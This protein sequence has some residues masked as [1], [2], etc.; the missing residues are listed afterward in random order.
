M[1]KL[2]YIFA[3]TFLFISCSDESENI[4]DVSESEIAG[5]WD[6]TDF[7]LDVKTTYVFQGQSIVSE[8][9][10]YGKDYD[11]SFTFNQN[12]NEIFNEGTFTI[13]TTTTT[14]AG[15]TQTIESPA[16][17]IDGFNSGSWRI[18]NGKLITESTENM[19]SEII[20]ESYSENKLVLKSPTNEELT[21]QGVSVK[22]KG[23][24]FL[25]LER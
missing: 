2:F 15:E 7:D 3:L 24:V 22:I 13:V 11:F 20:I 18:E 14:T 21:E 4:V 12:P 19:T 9:T 23:N 17:V 25:T 6:L 1:K 16:T 5:V 10:A 8:T